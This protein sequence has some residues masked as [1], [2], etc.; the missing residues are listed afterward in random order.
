MNICCH[1]INT[2]H[3][4]YLIR[5]VDLSNPNTILKLFVNTSMV[6]ILYMLVSPCK[7]LTAVHFEIECDVPYTHCLL[8][9]CPVKN[10]LPCKSFPPKKNLVCQDKI[11]NP[12][13]NSYFHI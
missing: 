9:A 11:Y 12:E 13:N 4:S 8:K 1:F 7:F 6:N 5:L 3:N 2:V 10:P